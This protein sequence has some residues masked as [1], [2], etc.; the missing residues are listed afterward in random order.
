MYIDIKIGVLYVS[1]KYI[2]SIN[3]FILALSHTDAFLQHK[4]TASYSLPLA[5]LL[6]D[7]CL[8]MR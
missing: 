4:T 3:A 6:S 2:N 7:F 5:F 8:M 1:K